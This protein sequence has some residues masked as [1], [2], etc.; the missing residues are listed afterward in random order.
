[1][2]GTTQHEVSVALHPEQVQ[3]GKENKSVCLL[4]SYWYVSMQHSM[5]HWLAEVQLADFA[6]VFTLSQGDSERSRKWNIPS[7]GYRQ[8]PIASVVMAHYKKNKARL[9]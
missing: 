9:W 6:H 3:F 8:M 7:I 5:S 2:V 4:W 1:M